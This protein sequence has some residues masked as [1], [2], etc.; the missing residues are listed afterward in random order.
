M[1]K[2][3]HLQQQQQKKTVAYIQKIY[4][5]RENYTTKQPKPNRSHENLK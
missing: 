4:H 1:Q 5:Q 2:Y 3:L